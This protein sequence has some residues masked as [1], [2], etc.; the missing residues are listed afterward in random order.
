MKSLISIAL[1]LVLPLG[2]WATGSVPT[3]QPQNGVLTYDNTTWSISNSFPYPYSTVPIVLFYPSSASA[4]PYTNTVST[5]GFNLDIASATGSNLTVNW[6]A[7]VG[8]QRLERGSIVTPNT[9]R[10]TNSFSPIYAF[11][12]QLSLVGTSGAVSGTV[13]TNTGSVTN[14]VLNVPVVT[15]VT[16][17]NFIFTVGS[18]NQ[19]IYWS[20]IGTAFA[21][22]GNIVTY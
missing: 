5:T 3:D 21:P 4:F 12:P 9:V 1:A 8:Y 17:S 22:G 14:L 6:S 19:T 20:A 16:P 13:T 10:Y 11:T 7:Y 2:A 15:S 18:T